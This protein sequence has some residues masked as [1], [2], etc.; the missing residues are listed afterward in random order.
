MNLFE[1]MVA[2]ALLLGS[3]AG[4]LQLWAQMSQIVQ[5]QDNQQR[6]SDQLEAAMT[7]AEAEL[8]REL[9]TR[10]SLPACGMAAAE[11]LPLLNAMALQPGI[12][13]QLRWISDDDAV[14]LTLTADSHPWPRQR[15]LRPAALGLCLPDPDAP[16][17]STDG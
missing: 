10:A 2:T 1:A 8:K 11:L 14:Q 17:T 3:S 7:N 5:V 4:S 6:I 12:Q 13:R 9:M 16:P 15:I